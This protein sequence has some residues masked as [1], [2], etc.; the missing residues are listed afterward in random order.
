M[1]DLS[2]EIIDIF[3]QKL[4]KKYNSSPR[5]AQVQMALDIYSYIK[6]CRNTEYGSNKVLF[7]EAPV[8]TGKSLGT[9]IPAIV[10][11]KNMHL[12]FKGV[13]YATATIGLQSQLWHE[14]KKTLI[15]LGLLYP[16]EAKLAMGKNNTACFK[17]YQLNQTSFSSEE[18][19]ILNRFF[20]KT[21][22]G[23]KDELIT[24]FEFDITPEK[25]DLIKIPSGENYSCDCVGHQYRRD[26]KKSSHLTITNQQ[27]LISAYLTTANLEPYPPVLDLKNKIIVIDEAHELQENFLEAHTKRFRLKDLKKVARQFLSL[28]RQANFNQMIKELNKKSDEIYSGRGTFQFENTQIAI[29]RSI[30]EH[31][32]EALAQARND[33]NYSATNKLAKISEQLDTMLLTKV[34]KSW[35]E[36]DVTHDTYEICYAPKNFGE[37]LNLFLKRLSSNNPLILLSGTFSANAGTRTAPKILAK[38]WYLT[39][40]EFI[41]NKYSSIFEWDKQIYGIGM[42]KFNPIKR[43]SHIINDANRHAFHIVYEIDVLAE[44][45]AGGILI[46]TT[47]L[48]LKDNIGKRLRNVS[49][50]IGRTVLVQK[51]GESQNPITVDKFKKD[52]KSILVG[53]GSYYTGFSVP[54]TALQGLV[55]T[56]LPFP[57]ISN[58]LYTI[59]MDELNAEDSEGNAKQIE[60]LK[61][62]M[63]FIKLE[64]GI[65]RLIRTTEDYGTLVITDPRISTDPRIVDWF[66]GHNILLHTNYDEMKTFYMNWLNGVDIEGEE[67]VREELFKDGM[68]GKVWHT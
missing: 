18:Q 8:G 35:Y 42:D 6:N 11:A 28:N 24:D 30:N 10:A 62:F 54:G 36:F 40:Q 12:P 65:G 67:Y 56:K 68:K 26:L 48:E 38:N 52:K 21:I 9:L 5:H 32:K 7:E 14:E 63:M 49:D 27:Q 51:K 61:Y 19:K 58:P 3:D 44:R 64:Q 31:L 43:N 2:D 15:D 4:A 33:F 53:S 47:S 25:W 29:F 57:V 1:T 37:N 55:I 16:H 39:N 17:G 46:L 59:K 45:I 41:L 66:Q 34:Y 13:I 50:K 23:L 60:E 20:K 22:T